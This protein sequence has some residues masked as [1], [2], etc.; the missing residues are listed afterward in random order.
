MSWKEMLSRNYKQVIY[1]SLFVSLAVP[2][3]RPIGLPVPVDKTT[4]DVYDR[5][6][7]LQPGDVAVLGSNIGAAIYAEVYPQYVAILEHLLRRPGVKILFVDHGTEGPIFTQRALNEV[8]AYTRK[9]YGEDF[10]HLGFIAGGEASIAGLSRDIKAL[11]DVDY[12][13]NKLEDLPMMDDVNGATDFTIVIDFTASADS[14]FWL[15]QA[16]APYGTEIAFGLTAVKVPDA[17]AYYTAGQIFGIIESLKGAAQ[18]E[19]LIGRPGIAVKGMD[20]QSLAH[21]LY[22]GLIILGNVIFFMERGRRV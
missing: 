20:A 3:M 22:I 5:I 14:Q 1:L 4:Q 9:A 17:Y 11:L 6:Q 2:L 16:Y 18:Y 8:N 13:G 12:E 21:L 10:V 7:A 19:V 15:N